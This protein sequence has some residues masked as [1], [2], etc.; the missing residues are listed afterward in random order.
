MLTDETITRSLQLLRLSQGEQARVLKILRR[1]EKDLSAILDAQD[2]TDF[3]RARLNALL[4]E[5]RG[6][7]QDYYSQINQLMQD[8][9]AG[10]AP[11]E[12]ASAASVL[13]KLIVD[14]VVKAEI[15]VD[16]GVS[17]PTENYIK[18]LV[19]DILI[20]GSPLASWW[21]RQA[22]DVAFRFAAEV[23]QGL[24]AGEVNG[25]IIRRIT[26]AAGE[27]G[28]MDIA[29]RNAAALVQTAVQTVANSARM[30]TYRKNSDVSKGVRF[31]STLD[32]HTC[33]ECGLHDGLAWD[34]DG[35]GLD[36]N[37]LPFE[38]PPLHVNCRCTLVDIPKTYAE[39]GIEGLP[40]IPNNGTRASS[41]GQISVKTTFADYLTRKGKAFQDEVL[42]P[43]RAELWRNGTIT[44]NQLLSKT[45]STLTLEQL[46]AL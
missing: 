37:T 38:I 13:T 21:S 3:G 36:G 4:K 42:G 24:A 12:A 15:T 17:L 9:I 11:T 18:A 23:R 44:L 28:V 35:N 39:M 34:F 14:P 26:G 8:T 7:I 31:V 22:G 19:S 43:G 10:L 25:A 27:P 46:K 41:D 5:A 6:V 30:A 20:E 40:E 32:T 29:R 45:G 1:M 16:I 33:I 2:L